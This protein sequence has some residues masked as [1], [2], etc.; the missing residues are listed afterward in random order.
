MSYMH[1]AT[2]PQID[3]SNIVKSILNMVDIYYLF[4]QYLFIYS[5]FPSFFLYYLFNI[6]SN[7]NLYNVSL[8]SNNKVMCSTNHLRTMSQQQSFTGIQYLLILFVL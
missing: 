4:I 1:C 7:I 3:S 6:Y 2:W 8:P 5:F